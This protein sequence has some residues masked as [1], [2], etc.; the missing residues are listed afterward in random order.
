MV[1][2][3]LGMLLALVAGALAV[4]GCTRSPLFIKDLSDADM[5]RVEDVNLC[6]AST[7]FLQTRGRTYDNIER[8]IARRGLRCGALAG[9]G[10]ADKP[11]EAAAAPEPTA[12]APTVTTARATGAVNMRAGPGT[13]HAVLGTLRVG[14]EVTVLSVDGTWCECMSPGRPRFFVSCRYLTTPAS[15]W[16]SFGRGTGPVPQFA[17]GAAYPSVRTQLLRLGWIPYR[18]SQPRLQTYLQLG[19]PT[20][21]G[22]CQGFAETIFCTGTGQA[23]C[24]YAWRRGDDY[25]LIAALGEAEGQSFGEARRCSGVALSDEHPWNWCR[26]SMRRD[27]NAQTAAVSPQSRSRHLPV[28][29]DP[30]GAYMF[31][32]PDESVPLGTTFR[33]AR[34]ICANLDQAAG[35]WRLATVEEASGL[36]VRRHGV[37]YT[38]DAIQGVRA[39][40]S[41]RLILLGSFLNYQ[42]GGVPFSQVL[43]SMRTENH[44]HLYLNVNSRTGHSDFDWRYF[45]DSRV[46]LMDAVVVP[47]YLQVPASVLCVAEAS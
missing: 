32:I 20:G 26:G 19:C 31:H 27:S 46:P 22:R 28:L 34:A 42:R 11:I 6:H 17:S 7:T 1:R 8:E 13:R 25:L 16:A 5:Q 36:L 14:D 41:R 45:D 2:P 12:P 3:R 30:T 44:G 29:E 37:Y 43:E 24:W 40:L 10:V 33:A 39:I 23:A 15:G 35:R 18:P 9:A 21:D 47:H 38:N 4:T